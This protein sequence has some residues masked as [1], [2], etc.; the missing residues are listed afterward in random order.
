MGSWNPWPECTPACAK[1]V[2]CPV[3]G[4]N[5]PPRGRSV[6]PEAIPSQCC[7]EHRYDAT[8]T[9]HLWNVD[10]LTGGGDHA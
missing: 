4:A 10:E 2:P 7:M 9:R 1:P 5:L 3:C 6:A 8:N